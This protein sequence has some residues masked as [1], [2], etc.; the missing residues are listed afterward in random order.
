MTDVVYVPV[1]I[2]ERSPSKYGWYLFVCD[3]NPKACGRAY[4]G[5]D[6]WKSLQKDGF[7]DLLS[8]FDL[9]WLEERDSDEDL[10]R[11]CFETLLSCDNVNLTRKHLP[12]LDALV[13]KVR[14]RLG[15]E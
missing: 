8:E 12:D 5:A 15:D 9:F 7:P 2:K 6:K 13:Q 1:N 3:G 4:Y 11:E 14:Q 10:L